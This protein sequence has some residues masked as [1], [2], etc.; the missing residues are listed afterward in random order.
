MLPEFI[1]TT[2]V[3]TR[4]WLLQNSGRRENYDEWE[5]GSLG[6]ETGRDGEAEV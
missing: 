6:E 2:K 1:R 4:Q 3:V 5:W